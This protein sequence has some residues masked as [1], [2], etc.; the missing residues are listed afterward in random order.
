MHPE[1]A[2][3]I[4]KDTISS[5]NAIASRFSDTRSFS[6]PFLQKL[7]KYAESGGQI[8]DIGC[9]NGILLESLPKNMDYFGID[10][11]ASLIE[12][13]G[14]KYEEFKEKFSVFNGLKIPF[15]DKS[16]DFVFSIAVLHHIPGEDFRLNHLKEI[17]RVLKPGGK[18]IIGVWQLWDRMFLRY[19]LGNIGNKLIGKSKIGFSDFYIPW[20]DGNGKILAE[21]YFHAFTLKELLSLHKKSGLN[22][23]E[24]GV[25]GAVNGYK[26]Y[27]VIS[28]NKIKS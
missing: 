18:A 8:L 10:V 1:I 24:K 12:E 11:S 5:Y 15:P 26:N 4:L 23:S 21:R 16:F 6:R 25:F 14:K 27:Y 19:F 9:G 22:I 17:T 2:K 28:T 3:E 7:A 13:A 20:K